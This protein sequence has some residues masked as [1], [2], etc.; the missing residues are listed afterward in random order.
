M[1]EVGALD[2]LR[3]RTAELVAQRLR[4][5]AAV[6]ARLETLIAHAV[7]LGYSH[8]SIHEA[9]TAGGL[10]TSWTNYRISLGRARKAQRTQE[11]AGESP[12][13]SVSS[14]GPAKQLPPL[15]AV[16]QMSPAPEAGGTSSTTDVLAALQRARRTA[17]KDYA[18]IAREQYRQ[19]IRHPSAI[20]SAEDPS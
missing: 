9:I 13:A 18:R 8:R 10:A 11:R 14:I 7:R 17:S 19:R 5:D 3:Y 16:A 12:A 1:S 4:S 20:P 6:V 15:T 2:Q